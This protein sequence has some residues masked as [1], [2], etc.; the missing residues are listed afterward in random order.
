MEPDELFFTRG[1]WNG[2]TRFDLRKWVIKH[3]FDNDMKK[4]VTL[5]FPTKSGQSITP[6]QLAKFHEQL[7]VISAAV[8]EAK[9]DKKFEAKFSLGQR[10]FFTVS[11]KPF[12]KC[13]FRKW[14]IPRAIYKSRLERCDM[15]NFE[16]D[17]RPSED[18]AVFGLWS[19]DK[20]KQIALEAVEKF[21]L[22]KCQCED[23]Q[24][25]SFCSPFE[26]E[27]QMA[28]RQI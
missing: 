21:G 20:C 11:S 19:F 7:D 3:E 23:P 5:V 8:E 15:S 28:K 2:N 25:C 24:I 17:L 1:I 9:K 16:S 10:L 12:F 6:Q 14:Y 27:V 4:F 13:Q 22:E 18:G 26:W